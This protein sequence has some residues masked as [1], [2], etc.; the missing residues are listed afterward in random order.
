MS[1]D[2]KARRQRI[3]FRVRKVVKGTAE[4][5]RLAVY[6]SNSYIYVQAIDDLKGNTLL[7]ASSQ[8]KD[9]QSQKLNKTEEAKLVGKKIGE[10]LVAAGLNEVAFDRGGFLYHGRVKS[11]AEGAREVGIKF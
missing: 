8:D 3:R 11:L 1:F 5:P 6:R 2:K 4:K 7:A 10:K 9:I